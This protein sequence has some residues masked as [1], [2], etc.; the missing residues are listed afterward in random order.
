[1]SGAIR[2]DTLPPLPLPFRNTD[3][4]VVGRES[5]LHRME[6]AHWHGGPSDRRIVATPMASDFPVWVNQDSAEV[7]DLADGFRLSQTVHFGSGDRL[8]ARVRPLSS[9]A[10]DVWL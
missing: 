10:W 3:R 2:A 5:V 4:L 7:T 8:N 1:M 9:D 6:F